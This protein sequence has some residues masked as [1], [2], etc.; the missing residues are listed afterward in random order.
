MLSVT[1]RLRAG[2]VADSIAED[3]LPQIAVYVTVV[4]PVLPIVTS[5][6]V[7]AGVSGF[8]TELPPLFTFTLYPDSARSLGQPVYAIH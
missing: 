1:G 7:S 2:D 3:P 6:W 8:A 5:S 4:E